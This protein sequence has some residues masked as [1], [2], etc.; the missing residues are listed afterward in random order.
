MALNN[1]TAATDM[2]GRR[3]TIGANVAVAILL[4]AALLVSVN[5]I[6]SKKYLRTDIAAASSFGLSA[7][8]KQVLADHPDPV[9]IAVLYERGDDPEQR[10][11]LDRLNDYLF[12]LQ[13]F[14]EDVVVEYITS[15][16]QRERLVAELNQTLG[17]EAGAHREALA[18]F[19]RLRG[20]L[21]T[22]IQ[23][24]LLGAE[25]LMAGDT[26][27]AD[28][29]LFANVVSLLRSDAQLLT[30]AA[31]EIDALT[32]TVGVPKFAEATTK[33]KETLTDV[34]EHLDAISDSLGKLSDL[35]TEATK[36]ESRYIAMLQDAA[37]ATRQQ[38]QALRAIVGE[39]NAPLPDDPGAVLKQFADQATR[40]ATEFTTIV[41]Q[42]DEFAARFPI[43]KQHADWSARVNMGPLTVRMEV[44]GVLEQATRTLRS[45]RLQALD[46]IDAGSPEQLRQAIAGSRN[47]V[48][49][50][51]DSAAACEQLLTNLAAR[52]TRLDEASKQ[53][54]DA[55]R[56]R[57]L[58]A[59]RKDAVDAMIQQIEDLPELKFGGIA[60][61]LKA[62]N[63]LIVQANDKVR[64]LTMDEVFLPR[65]SVAGMGAAPVGRSFN[66][67]SAIGSAV[68]ALTRDHRFGTVVLTAFE[69]PPPPQQ[70]MFSRPARS[71]IPSEQ[72]STV[73]ER[74]EAANFKVVD[75]NLATTPDP[76]EPDEGTENI[77]ICLPPAPP[78]PP[79]P[80]QQQQQPQKQFGQ[81]EA[82]KIRDI[83]ADDG[84]VLF[85]GTWEVRA[86]GMFG[87]PPTAAHYGYNQILEED[88]GLRVDNGRRITWVVPNLETPNGFNVAGP[89]INWM[90]VSGFTD[91]AIGK[92]LRGMRLLVNDCAPIEILEDQKPDNVMHDTVLKL[93]QIENYIAAE[94]MEL[95]EIIDVI[96]SPDSGGVIT[97]DPLPAS[98]ALPVFVTA[99]RE[100]SEGNTNGKIAV[101]GFGASLNDSYVDQPVISSSEVI[102]MDPPPAENIDWLLNTM[103]W[104]QGQT[105]W[106]ARGPSPTP[107]VLPIDPQ[108]RTFMRAFVWGIWPALVFA[109]GIALWYIRRR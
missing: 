52:L 40:V 99:T 15:D 66:G 67:D 87:G 76:P 34:K 27:L 28:F 77:Y 31:E 51:E 7:R 78:P 2:G 69:P 85:L 54:L 42:V 92:P 84:R 5:W 47:A 33:A 11:R 24:F 21:A 94:M 68:L 22:D 93:P 61:Q 13:R 82:Q 56:G 12:E 58:L 81:P 10:D 89:R 38:V 90:P 75:W 4:A 57:T 37:K 16:T 59:G 1:T 106:I 44:A 23:Q 60:D 49:T 14:D 46:I 102:R 43:V 109:P 48:S 100:N 70:N 29:P 63:I 95:M 96:R 91:H 6:A 17:T 83:L 55:A 86:G 8:T 41:Q 62:S 88:W 3:L 72:L 107:R 65:Q 25:S 79:N 80:F 64:V 36:P 101:C 18:S 71:W 103:F 97:I 98:G 9:R 53:I 32:P 19:A 45:I 105:H 50:L 73:R 104:L 26:W 35:A 108:E 39:E 30:D 20:E 74:L